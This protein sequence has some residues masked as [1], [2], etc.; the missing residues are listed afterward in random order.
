MTYKAAVIGLGIMGC[1]ADGLGGRH[2][3]W[4]PPCCHADAYQFHPKVQL[5][6]GCSRSVDKREY[7]KEKYSGVA[8]YKNFREL[9]EKEEID[10][11]SISTP[12]TCHAE[13]V[14][15]SAKASVKGIYCEKAM[16]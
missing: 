15:E 8:V 3:A 16:A 10:I 9:L 11:I 12:A 6:A 4:Y 13:M 2:P 7:F 5:V 14:I 1:V